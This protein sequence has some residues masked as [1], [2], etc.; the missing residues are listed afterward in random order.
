MKILFRPQACW[1]LA[2]MLA[3]LQTSAL[4]GSLHEEFAEDDGITVVVDEF[5][6]QLNTDIR[7][8]HIFFKQGAANFRAYL[9]QQSCVEFEGVCAASSANKAALPL[10]LGIDSTEANIL[11][12]HLDDALQKRPLSSVTR[13]TLLQKLIPTIRNPANEQPLAMLSVNGIE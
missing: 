8:N 9:L 5:L 1:L 7:I 4:A 13:Q 12:Q 2:L 10:Q 6:E 3:S 11:L